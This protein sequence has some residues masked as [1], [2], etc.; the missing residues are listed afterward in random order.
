MFF[1]RREQEEGVT[2]DQKIENDGSEDV[3]E[4]VDEASTVAQ[5]LAP[6]SPAV[7]GHSICIKGDVSGD[8]DLVID[9]KVEGTVSLPKSLLT[10]GSDGSL[11]ASVNAKSLSIEGHVEGDVDAVED[12]VLTSTGKMRGNIRAPKITLEEGCRFKGS[13]DMEV[14]DKSVVTDIKPTYVAAKPNKAEDQRAV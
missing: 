9:G 11:A 4:R 7:I 1:K 12:F 6:K 5:I 8:E 2:E 13:I 14:D 10:V 3:T